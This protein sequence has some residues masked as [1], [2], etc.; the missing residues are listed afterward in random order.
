MEN[1]L[2]IK[3]LSLSFIQKNQE[4]QAVRNVSLQ[5]P[6][7]QTMAI[8][9]ESGCG[10]ST[11]AKAI[12][13]LLPAHAIYKTGEI[14]VSNRDI[15]PLQEKQMQSI[16]GEV[17]SIVFQNHA[18]SLNPTMKIKKQIIEALQAHRSL[19]KKECEEE[20]LH[21][22]TLVQLRDPKKCLHQYPH[23]LS[24]GMRQRV[25][26]AIALASQPK[27]LILD[28]PTT[29]LDVTIQAQI[30]TL[31]TQLKKQLNMSIILITHDLYLAKSFCDLLVVMYAGEIVERG[32]IS[33]VLSKPY[34]PYT[35][36][37]LGCQLNLNQ[38]KTERLPYLTGMPPILSTLP[39]GCTF[40]NRCNECMEICLEQNPNDIKI[41]DTQ[42][43]N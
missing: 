34:H 29:S 41:N 33:Q 7:G 21:L 14:I 30:M 20:A 31:L 11:L 18:T 28:E 12:M 4:I 2:E 38:E 17:T 8:V 27:L 5:L 35:K 32:M 24:G 23:E 39:R 25:N 19:S 37:L 16:R 10:K 6:Y 36:A 9:G 15:I 13:K 43:V 3:N 22:L 42:Y 1:I 40:H 26:I